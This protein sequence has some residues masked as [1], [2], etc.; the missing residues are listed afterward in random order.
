MNLKGISGGQYKP[1]TNS[2][3]QDIHRAALKMLERTGVEVDEPEALRLFQNVGA[4]IRDNRVRLS[5]S[6]VEDAVDWAPT[7]VLLAGRDPRWDL[8]LEGKKVHIGG[9]YRHQVKMDII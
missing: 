7:K 3:V 8:E 9:I 6:L 4:K 5:R 1:L 2:Q